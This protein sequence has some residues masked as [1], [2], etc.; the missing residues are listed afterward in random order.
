MGVPKFPKLGLPRLWGP[1]TFCADFWLRWEKK[2]SHIP[3]WELSNNMWHATWTQVSRVDSRLLVVRSQTANLTPGLPFGHNLCF[4]C[5]N[6][7]CKTILYIYVSIDYQLYKEL[8]NPLG[9][10]PWNRSL[11]IQK[12]TETLN[13]QSG[14]SLGSVRVHSLTLSFT[15]GLPL[16][17]QPCKLLLWLRARG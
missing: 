16:G 5:P 2:K 3:R 15:P 11:K 12:S 9:F 13:S 8:F 6:E 14:N 17:S 10:D 4:R 7:S 1:I